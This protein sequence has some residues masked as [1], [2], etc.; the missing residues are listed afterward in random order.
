MIERKENEYN[1][2]ASYIL[3]LARIRDTYI[4]TCPKCKKNEGFISLKSKVSAKNHLTSDKSVEKLIL[5]YVSIILML[6]LY[7]Q[8]LPEHVRSLFMPIEHFAKQIQ[9][10]SAYQDQRK[11]I[12]TDRMVNQK[13]T[14]L[15]AIE[16]NSIEN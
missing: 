1:Y 3:I 2:D 14:L 6:I 8:K 16:S 5:R 15:N 4:T 10:V 12:V 7:Q 11:Q 9:R 13:K